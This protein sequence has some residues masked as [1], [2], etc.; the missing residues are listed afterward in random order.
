M[1]QAAAPLQISALDLRSPEALWEALQRK[2]KPQGEAMA[3]RL[4]PARPCN[5]RPRRRCPVACRTHTR[6]LQL[7]LA[8]PHGH[9]HARLHLLLATPL[10][11]S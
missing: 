2:D 9:L 6:D 8:L 3:A 5:C 11:P 1:A 10:P 4:R 7:L